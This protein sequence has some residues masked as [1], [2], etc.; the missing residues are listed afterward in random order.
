MKTPHQFLSRFHRQVRT[1]ATEQFFPAFWVHGC[2][3]AHQFVTRFP[4]RVFAPAN[5]EREQS[6]DGPNGNISSGDY[7][8]SFL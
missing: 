4:F 7:G 3:F 8:D 2:Q 5:A 1:H 6:G